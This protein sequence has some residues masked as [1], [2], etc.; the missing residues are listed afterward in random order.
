MRTRRREREGVM[1]I[2]KNAGKIKECDDCEH[3][4]DHVVGACY[5]PW[6]CPHWNRFVWCSVEGDD[7]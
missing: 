1:G 4:Q 5:L 3:G 7:G 6:K 2:C